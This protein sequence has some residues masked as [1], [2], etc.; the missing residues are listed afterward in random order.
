LAA[1][2]RGCGGD[3]GAEQ[4]G[5]TDRTLTAIAGE[6]NPPA[7]MEPVCWYADEACG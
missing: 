3:G 6:W 7:P 2:V 5:I 1:A 4:T